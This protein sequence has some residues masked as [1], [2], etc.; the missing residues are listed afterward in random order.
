MYC[1]QVSRVINEY[2]E[3]LMQ[4]GFL[5][6]ES[7][8]SVTNWSEERKEELGDRQAWSCIIFVFV[9]FKLTKFKV[10]RRKCLKN[11]EYTDTHRFTKCEC[12]SILLQKKQERK[13]YQVVCRSFFVSFFCCFFFVREGDNECV[14]YA[15]RLKG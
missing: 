1:E 10:R 7:L 2:N 14:V 3:C 9:S 6:G 4:Q 11:Q 15:W 12:V 13:F 8:I 5:S